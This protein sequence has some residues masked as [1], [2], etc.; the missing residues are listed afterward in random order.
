M[1]F[2]PLPVTFAQL[3]GL[4]AHQPRLAMVARCN[5]FLEQQLPAPWRTQARVCWIEEDTVWIETSQG[6]LAAKIRQMAP[7]LLASL[8]PHTPPWR[9]LKIRIQPQTSPKRIPSQNLST[10][11]LD[12]FSTLAHQLPEGE[13][14]QAIE[15]L[16]QSRG[17]LPTQK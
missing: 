14:R 13:L 1:S 8:P 10:P 9:T 6:S 12:A 11:T 5:A 4:T 7:R 16:L 15:M 2:R 3:E 17:K